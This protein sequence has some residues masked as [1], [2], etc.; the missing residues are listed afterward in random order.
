MHLKESLSLGHDTLTVETGRLAKQAAGSVT[1]QFGDTVI[2]VTVCASTKPREGIDFFPLVVDYIEKTYA[3]GKIPGGFFKREGRLSSHEVLVARLTDRPIRPLFPE[4]FRC[5]TQVMVTVLSADKVN[6][7]SAIVLN[8]A[9]AALML[10]DIPFNGPVASVRVCQVDGEFAVNPTFEEIE[11]ADLNL[12]VAASRDGVIMVEGESAFVA[13]ETVID[14][15]MFAQEQIQPLLDLQDRLREKVGRPKRAL[16]PLEEDE[17]L[18]AKIFELATGPVKAAVA[19]HDK[20]E[21]YS[22]L[23]AAKEALMERLGADDDKVAEKKGLVARYYDQVKRD[24]V[25]GEIVKGRRIGG[26]DLK[27]VRDIICDIQVLPRTHGS[28]LFTRG[29]TQVLATITLGTS[30]DEQRLD[31]LHADTTKS[32]MLHYN[33]PPFCVGEVKMLRGASRREIGHGTLA[34][35]GVSRVLP[36]AEDFPY[37]IRIVSEVLESNGSSSMA[38]VCAASLALMQA[39][40]PTSGH[41][42]GVA[43]GL[44]KENDDIRVLTD[45]LGDEDHLG[46][47]D[48]KVVG[49]RDGISA[50]QMDIKC[51]GITRD[52]LQTALNQA[53]VARLH[54]LNKM[55]ETIS[56]AAEDVSPYAPRIYLMHINPDRIR[57]VIGPGGKMIRSI[58]ER[59]G[60]QIDIEDSGQ[61]MVASADQASADAAMKIIRDLTA[62]VEVGRIYDGEVVKVVD[63]GAFVRILPNTDGLCHISE[64]ENHRVRRVED[65]VREGDEIQV[66]VLDVDRQGKIRLSRKAAMAERNPS[67][68]G[69]GEHAEG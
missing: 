19:I 68:G 47:M 24:Y 51:D 16:V 3:A 62:E 48:F 14:A 61:V 27:T 63:F 1:V 41:V 35:R 29:E 2:L 17:A 44:I 15:L 66:K 23:S 33:F 40:V 5:E 26:R 60:V 37:T 8:G 50:L 32:F 6:D 45:I 57:D 49:N 58:I 28:A 52:V 39:G 4:E 20:L 65:V 12:I 42:A 11:R 46:D 21:R 64:L 53:K 7:P 69:D 18:R 30:S 43:M 34:E 22:A 59:T 55:D 25:R 54:I 9:S 56:T 31:L 13:E 36:T 38:T 67:D 10:S